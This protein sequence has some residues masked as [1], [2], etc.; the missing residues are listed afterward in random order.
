VRVAGLSAQTACC[1]V[2]Y[3][4]VLYTVEER[5]TTGS[6]CSWFCTL[7]DRSARVRPGRMSG[8]AQQA[9]PLT[10]AGQTQPPAVLISTSHFSST[11][12]GLQKILDNQLLSHQQLTQEIRQLDAA[13]VM[14]RVGA[15]EGEATAAA[16]RAVE[17]AERAGS[18]AEMTVAAQP[19]L[20]ALQRIETR[21][22]AMEAKQ[23]AVQP[24]D[25]CVLM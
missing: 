17:S 20:E 1:Q 5:I 4:L 13:G 2:R 19:L 11:I 12:T 9:Q 6:A 3:A 10:A 21:L 7:F 24:V 14:A 22:A 16:S 18:A 8:D 25:C 15:A 23:D